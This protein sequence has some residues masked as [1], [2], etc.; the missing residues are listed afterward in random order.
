MIV[1]A[2]LAFAAQQQPSPPAEA[3]PKPAEIEPV[4][5]AASARQKYEFAG[6]PIAV[7]FACTEAT[8]AAAG[9]SCSEFEPCPVFLEL[10]SVDYSGGIFFL[11]GNLHSSANTF[12]SILLSSADEGKTWIEPHDR[13]PQAV[14]DQIQFADFANGWI[15]GQ[16]LTQFPRDPFFLATS[17]GGKTWRKNPLFDEE[18]A[19]AIDSFFFES[20]KNGTL[21]LDRSRSGDPGARYEVYETNTGGSTWILRETGPTLFKLKKTRAPLQGLRLRADG[22]TNSYRLEQSR[23]GRWTLIASFAVRLPECQL[24]SKELAQPPEP[25][26]PPEAEPPKPTGPAKPPSLKKKKS[27]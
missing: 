18:P 13:I 22:P 7:S 20:P 25:E 16:I 21:V 3:P 24:A 19:A 2:L 9:L 1:L 23:N 17:D 26:P 4:E 8:V 14:L 10:S 5:P 11:S 15:S 27:P 12:S 6:K